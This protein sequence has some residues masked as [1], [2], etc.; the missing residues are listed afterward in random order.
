MPAANCSSRQAGIRVIMVTGDHPLTARSI[1]EQIGIIRRDPD[2]EV[3]ACCCL[4]LLE[5]CRNQADLHAPL[6]DTT[7][8]PAQRRDSRIRVPMQ[9]RWRCR[10]I[11][12]CSRW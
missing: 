11:C 5:R 3:G 1:A 12:V 10:T 6:F 2:I 8:P 4:P 9:R 7:M